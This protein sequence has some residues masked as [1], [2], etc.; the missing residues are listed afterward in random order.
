VCGWKNGAGQMSKTIA[1]AHSL[2][3][4]IE[5]QLDE[6]FGK[7]GEVETLGTSQLKTFK[8]V[9]NPMGD[10]QIKKPTISSGSSRQSVSS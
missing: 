4:T 6:F 3:K 10:S 9:I 2:R 8:F 1:T 5:E 7:G